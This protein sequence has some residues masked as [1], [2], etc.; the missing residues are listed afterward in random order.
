MLGRNSDK[1]KYMVMPRDQNTGRIKNMNTHNRIYET[2][3]NFQYLVKTL[4]NQLSIE[5]EI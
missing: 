3:E 2:E 4:R 5:G 1:S